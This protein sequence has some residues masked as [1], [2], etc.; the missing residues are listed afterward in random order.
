MK[1]VH[2]VLLDGREGAATSHLGSRR[3][4]VTVTLG[5]DVES[6]SLLVCRDIPCAR[7]DVHRKQ[8]SLD[9]SMAVTAIFVEPTTDCQG[10]LG[11]PAYVRVESCG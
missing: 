8:S 7:V 2:V 4:R 1:L 5:S 3:R 6:S 11:C 10:R 9:R